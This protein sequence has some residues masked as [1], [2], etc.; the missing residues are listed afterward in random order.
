MRPLPVDAGTGTRPVDEVPQ[1][2][3]RRQKPSRQSEVQQ[4]LAQLGR[5]RVFRPGRGPERDA[6]TG[7]E[8]LCGPLA[9]LGSVFRTFGLYLSTRADLLARAERRRLARLVEGDE[10]PL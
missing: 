9:E 1:M 8:R 4:C 2:A 6:D 10:P 5:V 7:F 3:A